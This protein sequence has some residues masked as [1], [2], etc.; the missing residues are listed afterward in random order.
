[1]KRILSIIL[2]MA[3]LLTSISAFAIAYPADRANADVLDSNFAQATIGN[4]KSSVGN[5]GVNVSGMFGKSADD[6]SGLYEDGTGAYY[7][8][9]YIHGEPIYMDNGAELEGKLVV[10]F[11]FKPVNNDFKFAQIAISERQRNASEQITPETKGYNPYGWNHVKWVYDPTGHGDFSQLGADGK[12]VIEEGAVL[13][14]TVT[15]LNGVQLGTGPKTIKNKNTDDAVFNLGASDVLVQVYS[16]DKVNSHSAYI[17]DIKVYKEAAPAAPASAVLVAGSTYAVDGYTIIANSETKVSDIKAAN[18]ALEIKAYT[19]NSFATELAEDAVIGIDIYIV[20]KSADGLYGTYRV[21]DPM[22]ASYLVNIADGSIAGT[23]ISNVRFDVAREFGVGGKLPTDVS[24]K[25]THK[26]DD[27][28]PNDWSSYI[29]YA[30]YTNT[31]KTK[32]FVTE[33]NYYPVTATSLFIATAK[34]TGIVKGMSLDVIKANQWNKV[35]MY[36]DYAGENPV[37]HLFINGVEHENYKVEHATEGRKFGIDAHDIRIGY[38]SPKD[39]PQSAYIDD[40]KIYET[41]TRPTAALTQAPVLVSNSKTTIEGYVI[42]TELGA[43]VADLETDGDATINAISADG[44]A[45]QALTDG[46]KV[47]VIGKNKAIKTYTVNVKKD[48]T[49][50]KNI[51]SYSEYTAAKLSNPRAVASEVMGFGGKEADDSAV[52][53]AQEGKPENVNSTHY[54]WYIQDTWGT[55]TKPEGD[56]PSVWDK[57]NFSGY[58]VLETDLYN[59]SITGMQFVTDQGAV[60]SKG[61]TVPTGKWSKVVLIVNQS[62]DENHGKA[63]VYIDGEKATD[64]VEHCLGQEHSSTKVK[65]N[66]IRFIANGLKIEK[67]ADYSAVTDFGTA[68]IDNYKMYETTVFPG[69]EDIVIKDTVVVECNPDRWVRGVV[70]EVDGFAGKTADNKVYK[71][72]LAENASEETAYSEITWNRIS[73]ESQYLVIQSEVYSDYNYGGVYYA[74]S[75]HSPLGGNFANASGVMGAGKWNKYIVVIDL[76][77]EYTA[78]VYI[79]GKLVQEA[80]STSFMT[81]YNDGKNI[82]NLIRMVYPLEAEDATSY[83][84]NYKVYETKTYPEIA[85]SPVADNGIYGKIVLTDNYVYAEEGTIVDDI[86]AVMGKGTYIYTDNTFVTE[87]MSGAEAYNGLVAAIVD[88]ETDSIYSRKIVVVDNVPELGDSEFALFAESNNTTEPFTV[89]ANVKAGDVFVVKRDIIKKV[90]DVDEEGNALGEAYDTFGTVTSVLE[91]AEKDGVI[92][93]TIVPDEH[94]GKYR[95]F[96]FDNITS[97]RPL[98]QQKSVNI[99]FPA[100]EVDNV[101]KAN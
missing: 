8:I 53:L 64:W 15:Y 3:M 82:R 56:N 101:I 23:G 84:D 22:E 7:Y 45:T 63:I 9:R 52:K 68:Y 19:D 93:R 66:S 14:T 98:G 44:A 27:N 78:D 48:V 46:T 73:D 26:H 33:F 59:Q 94:N 76:N 38:Q 1:M 31:D 70:E 35:A 69:K 77:N 96:M 13:G 91:I 5:G 50:I 88:A 10:E 74:T 86:A 24:A 18:S 85:M 30:R 49:D 55:S 58:F 65:K 51:T 2:T 100:K 80:A 81:T 79:N 41:E 32:F 40:L 6:V 92:I 29:G 20:A 71:V 16:G 37:G 12:Y 11:N 67:D 83:F 87:E 99:D 47:A 36:V 25:I 4:F 42:K 97:I 39:T 54:N 60:V 75:Q 28:N 34:N 17:D 57:E 95:A 90:T 43:T 21:A 72:T 89:V 62:G 61:F